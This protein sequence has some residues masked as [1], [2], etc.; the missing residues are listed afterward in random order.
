[1]PVKTTSNL[2]AVFF[3]ILNT[4]I[5]FLF[6]EIDEIFKAAKISSYLIK[7]IIMIKS[8]KIN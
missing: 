3:C 7:A 8:Q 6:S 2:E 1:M 4:K 5:I